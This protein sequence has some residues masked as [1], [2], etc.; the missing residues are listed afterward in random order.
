MYSIQATDKN[1]LYKASEVTQ[2]MPL[3]HG[4][5]DSVTRMN[6]AMRTRLT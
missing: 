3:V 4:F 1:N 6:N 5:I 2:K